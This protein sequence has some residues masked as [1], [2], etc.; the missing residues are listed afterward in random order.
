MVEAMQAD[1]QF[2]AAIFKKV[3]NFVGVE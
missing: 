2:Y 1:R 3:G